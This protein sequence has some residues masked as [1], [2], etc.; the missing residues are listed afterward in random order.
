MRRS[1]GTVPKYKVLSRHRLPYCL[2]VQRITLAVLA[3]LLL[4]YPSRPA[5]TRPGGDGGGWRTARPMT[6]VQTSPLA[7]ETHI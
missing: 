4:S 3:V 2:N 1:E 5:I 6:G 7:G